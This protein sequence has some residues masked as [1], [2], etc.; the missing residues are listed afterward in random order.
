MNKTL[1]PAIVGAYWN[2]PIKTPDGLGMA[3]AVAD[4]KITVKLFSDG[5]STLYLLSDCQLAAKPMSDI[6]DDD[7]KECGSCCGLHTEGS[8]VER[9]VNSVYVYNDSYQLQIYFN[10]HICL[11]KNGA[12]YDQDMRRV[13]EYLRSKSYYCDSDDIPL[14]PSRL[15]DYKKAERQ[16]ANAS[17]KVQFKTWWTNYLMAPFSWSKWVDIDT[18]A[19]NGMP[20]LLQGKVNRSTNAKKFRIT[21]MGTLMGTSSGSVSLDKLRERGL[22]DDQVTYNK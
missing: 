12:I 9:E 7:A 3:T 17:V 5:I 14:Y 6:T 11:R 8:R 10:G 18:F 16:N 1:T 13:Y 19:F 15:P 22:I 21:R 4:K 2:T 20:Y